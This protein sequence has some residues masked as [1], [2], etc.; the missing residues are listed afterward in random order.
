VGLI[1]A[2]TLLPAGSAGA[3]T[4]RSDVDIKENRAQVKVDGP[5]FDVKLSK[6]DLRVRIDDRR[7]GIR[8]A[9]FEIE[10]AQQDLEPVAANLRPF[11]CDN[12]TYRVVSGIFDTTE[13]ASSTAV[14]P[15]PFPTIVI[16]R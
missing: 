7:F 11:A 15:L 13:R 12:G 3:D 14:R 6:H 8:S 5:G 10:R 16:R 1:I 4:G 2:L 9:G